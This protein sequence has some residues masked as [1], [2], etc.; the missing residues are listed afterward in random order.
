LFT[1]QANGQPHAIL[2]YKVKTAANAKERTEMLDALRAQ[3][4]KDFKMA[5]EFYVDDFKVGNNYAWF[6]G[7]LTGKTARKLN[8][9]RTPTTAATWKPYFKKRTANGPL[10]PAP[11]LAAMYGTKPLPKNS[12]MPLK[13]FFRRIRRLCGSNEGVCPSS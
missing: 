2:E 9:T 3:L 12:P 8:L 10:P 5:L 7:R 4:Y 13:E 11:S 6:R 1:L